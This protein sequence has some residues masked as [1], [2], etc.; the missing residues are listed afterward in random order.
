[1]LLPVQILSNME[2][3]QRN[4][5]LFSALKEGNSALQQLQKQV[6]LEDVERLNEET[7]DAHDYQDQLR[8]LLGQSLSAQDDAE[9]LEELE[10][11]QVSQ[12][13]SLCG[14]IYPLL[15]CTI[16]LWQFQVSSSAFTISSAASKFFDS[17]QYVD[18]LQWLNQVFSNGGIHGC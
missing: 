9:A 11:I 14:R 8:Q 17:T 6:A 13:C 10:K 7:A 15:S 18:K 16:D 4:N 1:M 2:A 3:A 5:R 12:F